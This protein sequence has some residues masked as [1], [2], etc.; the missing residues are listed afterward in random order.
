M[1][2]HVSK[3]TLKSQ[4]K[5]SYTLEL[6]LEAVVSLSTWVLESKLRPY[7]KAASSLNCLNLRLTG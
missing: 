3:S 2:V 1:Y 4:K 6:E 5:A 7:G